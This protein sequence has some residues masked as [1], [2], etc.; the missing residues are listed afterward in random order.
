MSNNPIMEYRA[1]PLKNTPHEEQS[2]RALIKEELPTIEEQEF[3]NRWIGLF[4]ERDKYPDVAAVWVDRVAQSPRQPVEVVS[5]GEVVAIVPPMIGPSVT[6]LIKEHRATLGALSAAAIATGNNFPQ[7]GETY[8]SSSLIQYQDKVE[9]RP[10]VLMAQEE[11]RNNWMKLFS[12]YGLVQSVSEVAEEK[13]GP[14]N[15]LNEDEFGDIEDDF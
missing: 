7:L 8:L 9:T 15:E 1:N 6:E 2:L 5:G 13:A 14:K 10:E 12:K 11:Y 3:L 4:W